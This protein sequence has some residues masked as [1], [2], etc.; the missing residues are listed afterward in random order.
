MLPTGFDCSPF[1]TDYFNGVSSMRKLF[2]KVLQVAIGTMLAVGIASADGIR[3]GSDLILKGDSRERVRIKCGEPAEISKQTLLRSSRLVIRGRVE[4]HNEE[5]VE[6]PVEIWT[7][8]F[9][10]N[11]LMERIR[12]VDGIVEHI[13]TLGYGYGN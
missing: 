1:Q 7:Y 6:I 12:F 11:R 2:F 8:N 5:M 10:S 3:C 13:D 4:R 9:G